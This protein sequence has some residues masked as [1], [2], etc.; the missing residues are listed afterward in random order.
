MNR[1][2]NIESP[3]NP[4]F[5]RLRRLLTG[6]GV[7]KENRALLSGSR[8][9]R[10]A[11]DRFPDRCEAWIIARDK[12]PGPPAG[13]PSLVQY[14]LAG[15][16]FRRLD[17]AGTRAPLLLVRPPEP[18]PWEPTRGLPPGLSLFVPFQDPEN[19]GAVIRS[20]AA[21]GA[22][23]VILLEGSAHPF[24]PKAVRASG[25]S[26]LQIEMRTGPRLDA[27]PAELPLTPLSTE[28]LD[29]GRFRF[30]DPCGL[31]PGVEGEGLPQAWRTRSV[32]I[33]MDSGVESLNAA[34]AVAVAL[35]LWSRSRQ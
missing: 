12:M 31:L 14:R 24:H 28:G 21:F 33:P 2:R 27:L 7:R 10:E 15:E 26:V 3:S 34:A 25:G 30:P 16:L 8:M 4:V 35:Y 9:V 32:A 23:R 17:A 11:L 13:F 5:R 20:A 18:R 29:I 22:N 19:V 6:A 1:P